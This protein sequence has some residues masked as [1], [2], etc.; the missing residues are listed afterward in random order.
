VK[1]LLR[2]LTA[3][4]L[5]LA[6]LIALPARSAQA[7]GDPTLE[8]WTI[9]TPHF[10]VHYPRQVEPIATRVAALAERINE[11]L[12]GPLGYKPASI[13][14]IVLTDNTDSANGSA[15]ALPYNTIR[16][17]V[18]APEDLSPLGD[19]DDWHLELLTHEHTHI[20]HVDNVSGIPAIL[21]AI[22]GKTFVPNQVQPRWVIEGLAV[23]EETEHT[24]AGRIRSSLFDMF[25]RADVL[26]D[27]IASLDQISS[28]PYRYPQG[29]LWYLYGSRFLS[30]ISQVY[31]KNTM[32]AVSAEYGSNI[33]PWGIN[34][35]IRRATGRTYIELYEGFKDHIR[36]R[37]AQQVRAVEERGLR[38]GVRITFHGRDV[39]YPRFVPKSGKS[40]KSGA[41]DEIVY[42]RDD[43]HNRS[44][45][46]RFPL[47]AIR[48]GERREELIA[49]TNGLSVATFTPQGDLVFNSVSVFRQ[50]YARDDLYALPRGET[51][52]QGDEPERRRLTE[53]MRATAPD[54]SP[55]GRRVVFTVNSLGTTYLEIADIEADGS[56]KGRR[57]LVPSARFEQAYTPRFSPDGARV[58][59][60]AWTAGG[61]RDIRIVDVKTGSFRAVTRDRSLDMQPAW[62]PDGKTL[63]FASDRTGILNIYAYDLAQDS[64]KQVTNV[65]TGATQP[66]VS[67]DGRTLVY[68]GYTSQGYDLY[69]MPL[70][71][72]RFL[73]ALPAPTDRPDPP[74]EPAD[75]PLKKTRY[76]PLPTLAPRSYLL[77]LAPGKYGP[78]ALTISAT[79]SDVVGIHGV[80]ASLIIDPDAPSPE[81]VLDYG[82]GRLPVDLGMRF[83]YTV[84]PR[85]GYRIND[86]VPVY[87]ERSTGITVGVNYSMPQN[88]SGH[89]IG[90]SY[91]VAT[92]RGDLPVG[93]KLDPYATTTVK[94]ASGAIGV[95]HLGYSFSNVEGSID[96]AGA[97]RGL[98]LNLSVDFADK[99]TGGDYSVRAFGGSLT[100]YVPMPWPG[101]HVLALRTS[102]AVAGG[103]YPRGNIYFVGGYN[104]E[105]VSLLDTITTGIFNGAFVLRGYP[106]GAYAGQAYFLQNIEYR[107]PLWKP[108][109]GLST[110][111]IYLQRVDANLFVDY[112]GAFNNLNFDD[113]KLFNNGYLIDSSQLHASVGGELWFGAA[114]GYVIYTQFRLGYAYGFSAGAVPSGQLYFVASSAF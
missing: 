60:S 72:A 100:G 79:G 90:A 61:Y 51:S 93:S 97:V 112:G 65:R 77:E 36:R 13:T 44:G 43:R 82:Y 104:L 23:L 109:R 8:W 69:A 35:S 64:L 103:S 107:A 2:S 110:L 46:Y 53:G 40:G 12:T 48:E 39:H 89:S 24:S 52:T 1:T 63:Y 25:L 84:S 42:Y 66:A 98:S 33:I 5:A 19:Y 86:A 75:I 6:A 38:E 85:V 18:T 49:R 92:F 32:R 113:I 55:D 56:L 16:L 10:R 94:P 105:S 50:I 87:N 22:L 15:T 45:I 57:D 106:P 34:R 78:N 71:P 54:V 27:N 80:A 21:N 73:E 83:F 99:A 11:R 30:W 68:V 108:D 62:S 81:L 114:L 76:S 111:P 26:E 67:E 17:Y 3:L 70:D 29:Q 95:V 91:S 101:R 59:Y 9:E 88:F 96:T 41:A 7:A 4:A 47:G 74:T 31:G 20:L 37:Y 102:G 14:H 28:T 58:A